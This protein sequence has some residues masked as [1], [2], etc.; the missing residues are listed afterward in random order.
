MTRINRYSDA[1]RKANRIAAGLP[2]GDDKPTDAQIAARLRR[3]V[4]EL[5]RTDRTEDRHIRNQ[6]QDILDGINDD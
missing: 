4:K 3:L 1:E 2:L 5:D 6:L